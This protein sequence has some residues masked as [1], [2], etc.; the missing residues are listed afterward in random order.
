[1]TPDKPPIACSLTTADLRRHL[2]EV[3]ALGTEALTRRESDNNT[4]TLHFASS[5]KTQ[6]RLKQV[7]ATESRCC[8]FLDLTLEERSGELTLTI[9]TPEDAQPIA[10]ELAAAFARGSA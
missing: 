6:R 7:I 3:A 10:D 2:D 1:M 9:A 4:H 8:P 5:K